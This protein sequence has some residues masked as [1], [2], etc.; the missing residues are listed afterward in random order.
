M[1]KPT[2]S[3]PDGQGPLVLLV[4]AGTRNIAIP[5]GDIVETL[6]PLAVDP[7]Q[8]SLGYLAGVSVVRGEP[9]PVVDL[10]ALLQPGAK[11]GQGRWVVL[12]GKPS[13]VVLSVDRI[14]GLKRLDRAQMKEVPPLLREF[15]TDLARAIVLQDAH[16]TTLIDA[17]RI[18]ER[19][20]SAPE[21][22]TVGA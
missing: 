9:V 4:Q 15:H 5:L 14:V 21:L 16:C 3:A 10:A 2:T 8:T 17:S 7:L 19:V 11:G 13:S 18:P 6:R 12:K 1:N 20:P 22:L